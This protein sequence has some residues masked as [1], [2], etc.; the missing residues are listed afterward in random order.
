[1]KTIIIFGEDQQIQKIRPRIRDD[2]NYR[3]L[4]LNSLS[5]SLFDNERMESALFVAADDN[6]EQLLLS[7][8]IS[9]DRI[10]NFSRFQKT[11]FDNPLDNFKS[12]ETYTGLILGMSHSQ[13]AIDPQ[14]LP[15]YNYCKL[16]SP[17]FD[18]FCQLHFFQK[19]AELHSDQLKSIHHV[20]IE[21]PYYIFN[22]DLSNFGSFAYTKLN[23]FE[24]VDN[25]H[26]FG[27]KLQQKN[28]I[29]QFKQFRQLFKNERI[30]KTSG[31]KESFVRKTAKKFY[32]M[33]R[34]A[35]NKDKVWRV[36]YPDTIQE[37]KE[38]WNELKK[39]LEKTCPNAKITVVIMPFNPI[40][41][42]F[43][44]KNIKEMK[45]VFFESLGT[46]E[47]E[48]VDHFACIKRNK[49]FDD[50]CHLNKTGSKKYMIKLKN[51]LIDAKD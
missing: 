17:S 19:L 20:I 36:A 22:F 51:S 6:R 32:N 41:R 40:F 50:H 21:L 26:H 43:H 44:A 37:N 29:S 49:Y 8:G 31:K 35:S 47:F 16:A 15:T 9:P 25:Y 24:I 23:Y 48:I 13:C 4:S 12:D 11:T 10:I 14:Q 45:S 28:H 38:L 42:L 18:L 30:E 5:Q 33:Y 46:G 2:A 1:M 39:T 27:E 7:G 34:I 3:V